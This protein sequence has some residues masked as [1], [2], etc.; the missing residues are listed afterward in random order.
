MILRVITR[1][2][3]LAG[4]IA[5]VVLLAALGG[6]SPAVAAAPWWHLALEGRPANVQPGAGKDAVQEVTVSATGGTFAL[7]SLEVYRENEEGNHREEFAFD[8]SAQEVR[9]GLERIFGAGTV[10][11]TGG[12]GDAT[13]SKPYEI[14]FIGSRG[15]QPVE[16]LLTSNFLEGGKEEANA[17]MITEG[18]SA[19][20]IG[21][22]S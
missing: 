10:E 2:K 9:E 21:V 8:A 11:V 22:E 14:R 17:T 6:A 15:D 12:P 5:F 13:G 16:L 19:G 18:R 3:R 4:A 1:M 7:N 20:E